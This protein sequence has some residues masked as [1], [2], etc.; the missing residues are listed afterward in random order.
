MTEQAQ[1]PQAQQPQDS[2]L[3][4]ALSRVID[5][6]IRRSITELGM[7]TGAHIDERGVAKA[8]L[9]LTIA[10]CPAA[11]SLETQSR[12][13]L[14]SVDGVQSA[15]LQVKVMTP[16]EREAFITKVRGERGSRPMQFGA[17]SLT[18]VIAVTSGKGGVGKSTVT[19]NLAYALQSLGLK[20]AIVDADVF[21][22]SIPGL[23]GLSENGRVA[24]PV[25]IDDMIVAPDANGVRVISIGMFLGD[26]DTRQTAVSWRGPMLHRTMEQF[27]RDVWFGDLDVLLLDLPPGTGDVA[28]SLGQ[29]LPNAE[30]LVI[31]TP[32]TSAS[33]VAIRSGILSLM[34]GQRLL[35]VVENM[36]ALTLPDGT[37]VDMFGSGGAQAVAEGLT[38]HPKNSSGNEV[39]VLAQVPLSLELRKSADEGKPIVTATPDDPA[40]VAIF[41]LAREVMLRRKPLGGS[42]LP[43]HPR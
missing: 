13:A 34:S 30:V 38:S 8:V 23:V 20:V 19:V 43:I 35:G 14:L 39:K 3:I 41:D 4:S 24:S 7:V 15:E 1:Q 6:D 27:L 29:L 11:Q 9:H 31:T 22:F 10:G 25:R 42:R 36:S 28:L 26:E 12:E 21:G 18:R 32:Q 40:A 5:P 17:D 16:A 2:R 37:V 33:D